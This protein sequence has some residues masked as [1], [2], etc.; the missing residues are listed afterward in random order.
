ME[1]NTLVTVKGRGLNNKE[2]MHLKWGNECMP[3]E[4][5]ESN[6]SVQGY[7]APATNSTY[8]GP[9]LI[10]VGYNSEMEE[11]NSDEKYT[12]YID[13]TSDNLEFYYYK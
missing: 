11:D 8:G 9:V 4:P 1:G 2:G 6:D 13:Y 10:E 12:M 3:V 5:S 7:S